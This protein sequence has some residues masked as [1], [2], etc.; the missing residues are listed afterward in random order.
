[1]NLQMVPN[2]LGQWTTDTKVGSTGSTD[3]KGLLR[4]SY[5]KKEPFFILYILSL[6]RTR[7]IMESLLRAGLACKL[8]AAAHH[9]VGHTH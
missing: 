5:P 1:M 7:A 3:H 2:G 8:Q 6:L 9:P 4:R